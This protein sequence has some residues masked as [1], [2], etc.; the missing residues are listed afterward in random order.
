MAIISPRT[1]AYPAGEVNHGEPGLWWAAWIDSFCD[2]RAVRIFFYL[3]PVITTEL[4]L[5]VHAFTGAPPQS[6]D[7]V[8]SDLASQSQN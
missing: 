6:R 4:I 3:E 1:T 2:R 8:K 7:D 5:P